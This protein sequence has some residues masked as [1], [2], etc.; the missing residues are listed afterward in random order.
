VE[1][2]SLVA[3]D[4]MTGEEVW[5]AKGIG[6]SWNTPVLVPG[7]DKTELVVSIS[8]HVVSLNP[9]TGE[10]L[11]R[12]EGVHR[13]VC[14]SV[15]FHDDVVYVIGGGHTSLAVRTGGSGDVTK[16]HGLWRLNKG[17]NVSSPIYYKGHL[18][19]TRD[20]NIVCCQ[21]PATGEMVYED[22]LKPSS[23]TIWSSPVLADGKLYYV[24]QRNGTFVV[25]AQPK[26]EL[27]A[28][29]KF[30]DDDSRTNASP[31]VGNGQLLLRTDKNLY[32]IGSK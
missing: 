32:C 7:T 22:R 24:S 31:A 12:A 18:Y 26:F 16:T 8:N 2:R 6:S 21:N 14:P 3:L 29:N 25:A 17:A 9:D 30:E 5:R 11:W 4:K 28:H 13:Y 15:V 27:L 10:E 20:G 23:G 1:S 19:W